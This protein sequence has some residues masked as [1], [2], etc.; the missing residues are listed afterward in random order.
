MDQLGRGGGG[1]K[2][3]ESV[4]MMKLQLKGFIDGLDVECQIK[5]GSEYILNVSYWK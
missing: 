3:L 5:I 1:E 4:Y 2:R